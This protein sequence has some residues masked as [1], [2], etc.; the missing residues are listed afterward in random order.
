MTGRGELALRG[1]PSSKYF[2][3]W[4]EEIHRTF[5]KHQD[6]RFQ[7][8]KLIRMHRF[9]SGL[10]EWVRLSVNPS[11]SYL[12]LCQC[13]SVVLSPNE[14]NILTKVEKYFRT[15]KKKTKSIVNLFLSDCP[16]YNNFLS[17]FLHPFLLRQRKVKYHVPSNSL[18][19]A[20]K[21]TGISSLSELHR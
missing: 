5:L 14:T 15:K 3:P 11:P 18:L 19:P 7:E 16:S 13:Y 9:P 2:P 1:A 21:A 20:S 4:K 6:P 10:Q 17:W 12:F 8:E